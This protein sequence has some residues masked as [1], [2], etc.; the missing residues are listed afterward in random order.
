M[1][2]PSLQAVLA[3][4]PGLTDRIDAMTELIPGVP[5]SKQNLKT[6]LKHVTQLGVVNL[7]CADKTCIQ[8]L[9]TTL[10]KNK[11]LT[12]NFLEKPETFRV[13]NHAREERPLVCSEYFTCTENGLLEGLVYA[14][15]SRKR[16]REEGPCADCA[17][18]DGS[19]SPM[20]KLK[21]MGMPKCAPCMLKAI[22]A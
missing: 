12:V 9:V 20:K 7:L 19:Q 5:A 22:V 17:C 6:L 16:Y 2:T 11:E 14:K 21:A 15:Q 13:G 3:S 1:A 18:S 8:I 4:E 10:K